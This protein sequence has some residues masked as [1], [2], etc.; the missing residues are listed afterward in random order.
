[1]N[2]EGPVHSTKTSKYYTLKVNNAGSGNFMWLSSYN[3]NQVNMYMSE[4]QDC[5][6]TRCHHGEGLTRSL[7]VANVL[8]LLCSLFYYVPC[9][10]MK[11]TL[12]M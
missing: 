8:S 2:Y 6:V 12:I 3:I 10:H 1:M 9:E 5:L 11:S 7:P 4:L